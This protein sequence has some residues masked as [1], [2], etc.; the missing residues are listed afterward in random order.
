[1]PPSGLQPVPVE[2]VI[3]NPQSTGSS[4]GPHGTARAQAQYA[5]GSFYATTVICEWL[6]RGTWRMKSSEDSASTIRAFAV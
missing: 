1:M 4:A 2:R 3:A 6:S 5:G